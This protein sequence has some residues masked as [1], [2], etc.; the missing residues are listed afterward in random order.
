MGRINEFLRIPVEFPE[1]GTEPAGEGVEPIRDAQGSGTGE[2]PLLEVRGLAFSHGG[3]GRGSR[4]GVSPS[5]CGRGGARA[6]GAHRRREEHAP[7]PALRTLPRAARNGLPR[8]GRRVDAPAP[9]AAPTVR[10]GLPGPVPFLRLRPRERLLRPDRTDPEAARKATGLARFLAEVEEMPNGFDTVVGERG[11][12][13]SGGRSSGSRSPAPSAPVHRSCCWTTPFPPWT[14]R[15]S[16]RS[17]RDPLGKGERTSCSARTG[18][19]PSPGATGSSCWRTAGSSRRGRTTTFS[20]GAAPTST[21]TPARC[22]PGSWRSRREARAGRLLHGRPRRNPGIDRRLLARL[23]RYV[24]PTGG[25]SRRPWR[26]SSA[27][28]PASWRGR[29]SSRSSS[30]G[31]W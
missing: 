21:C 10:S 2:P 16:G 30:T 27:G 13:L 1:D 31:T 4:S 15:R 20:P 26:R 6:G 8:R 11:I 14:P 5:P 3:E 12:S 7:L 22:S 19:P 24:L 28:P 23:L 18:W 29:T 17:S 9:R 25:S